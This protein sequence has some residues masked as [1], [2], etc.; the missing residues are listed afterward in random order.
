MKPLEK[1]RSPR[2]IWKQFW[3]IERAVLVLLRINHRRVAGVAAAI[4]GHFSFLLQYS[5]RWFS[6][7]LFL[8]GTQWAVANRSGSGFDGGI[9]LLSSIVDSAWSKRAK[10]GIMQDSEHSSGEI[11]LFSLFLIMGVPLKYAP[12]IV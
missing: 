3:S 7:F 12:V 11:L 4:V 1:F 8:S 2:D 10:Q 5:H 6:L 9:P